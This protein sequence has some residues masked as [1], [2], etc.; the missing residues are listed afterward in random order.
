MTAPPMPRWQNAVALAA[1]IAAG[2][3]LLPLA[4]RLRLLSAGFAIALITIVAVA[5]LGA[6]RVRRET[7]HLGDTYAR[8]DRIRAQRRAGRRNRR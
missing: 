8:I 3:A 7:G 2:G 5:R 1:M 6:H 4:P